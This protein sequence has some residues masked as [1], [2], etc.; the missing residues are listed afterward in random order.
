MKTLIKG[1][2]VWA[3]LMMA[4]A[5]VF[6]E[7][8]IYSV[9]KVDQKNL[10]YKDLGRK[11]TGSAAHRFGYL[12]KFYAQQGSVLP[13]EEGGE[14]YVVTWRA[15]EIATSPEHLQLQFEYRTSKA[16]AILK[17]V[18]DI[19]VDRSGLYETSIE[20]KRDEILKEGSI[21]AWRI[22]IVKEG[23]IL[24]QRASELWGE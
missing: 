3:L 4:T 23:E 17:K 15:Q 13:S 10:E 14:S 19:D 2:L 21:N 5:S 16:S 22:F 8:G 1:F 7:T 24:A 20:R 18:L 6:S 11:T 12:D 9:V